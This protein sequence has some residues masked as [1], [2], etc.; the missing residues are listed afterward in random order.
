MVV[1]YYMI[2]I[3]DCLCLGLF[4]EAI[5]YCKKC[6]EQIKRYFDEDDDYSDFYVLYGYIELINNHYAE[7]IEILD[8]AERELTEEMEL[9]KNDIK[10]IKRLA[11]VSDITGRVHSFLGNQF[12][13]L[14]QLEKTI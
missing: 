3:T 2:T 9:N 12:L 14:Q 13:A 11:S 10:I 8:N 5:H 6:N 4:H 1:R 7:A